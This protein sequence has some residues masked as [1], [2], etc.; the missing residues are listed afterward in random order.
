MRLAQMHPHIHSV[1]EGKVWYDL[2][3]GASELWVV[4]GPVGI[5]PKSIDPDHLPPGFRW[6]SN[7]EWA[8]NSA[9]L[10]STDE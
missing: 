2:D 7:E 8:A 10:T 9:N 5:D 4:E 6:V 1:N 3:P